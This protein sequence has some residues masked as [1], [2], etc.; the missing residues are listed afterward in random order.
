MT[1]LNPN[2]VPVPSQDSADNSFMQD[3]VGNKT[4]TAGGDSLVAINTL[5]KETFITLIGTSPDSGG[6]ANTSTRIELDSNASAVDGAYDPSVINIV[7]GTGVGQARQIWEYDGTNK[8]AYVNRD[9]KVIPDSTS[10]YVVIFNSGDSHVNEGL[11]QAGTNDTVTLNTLASAQN[12]IYLGQ[13]IYIVAGTGADQARMVVGYVGG[14]KVATVDSNWIVNPDSTSIYAMFPFPGF[15]HGLPGVDSAANV[16]MRDVI[17]NKSDTEAGDSLVGINKH[18]LVEAQET[19][20]HLHNRERWGGLA[21]VPDA[22]LHRADFDLMVPFIMDAGNNTWGAWLQVLGST[23]TPVIGGMTEFDFHRIVISD[24]ETDDTI[25]RIQIGWGVDGDQTIIDG[26]YTEIM[27][28][29]ST[30][31]SP[32]TFYDIICKRIPAG[33]KTWIRCW[34]DGRDT[35]TV[36]F[37][38][39]LHEYDINP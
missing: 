5:I 23:D 19:E 6:T 35:S 37:F 38:L 7:A 21:A 15:I 4:D 30:N 34:V 18:T 31:F 25:T 24:V 36:S 33:T 8:Y 12:N 26:T 28:A 39:G 3:V 22:E 11:A 1:Y 16:L 2:A 27:L 13:C 20:H 17:G 9:W 14:T 32:H 29:L 10:E